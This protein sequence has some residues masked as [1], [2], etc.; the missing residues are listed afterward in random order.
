MTLDLT[1]IADNLVASFIGGWWT[2]V[3]FGFL[4]TKKDLDAAHKKLRS[5]ENVV[6]SNAKNNSTDPVETG[7]S[8]DV[9]DDSK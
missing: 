9:R 4:R 3:T 8:Q 2:W 1:N 6:A 7:N 5:L